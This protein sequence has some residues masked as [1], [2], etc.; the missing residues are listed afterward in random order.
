MQVGEA[1]LVLFLA[2]ST[3]P[4]MLRAS[5]LSSKAELVDWSTIG[6]EQRITNQ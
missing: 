1:I 3:I 5:E 2:S 6:P 4:F